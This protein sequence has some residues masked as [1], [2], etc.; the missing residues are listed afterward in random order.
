MDFAKIQAR[1]KEIRDTLKEFT[2]VSREVY[3]SHSYA[4]GYLES[5]L[6]QSMLGMS[7]SQREMILRDLNR[8]IESLQKKVDTVAA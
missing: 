2:D 1:H 5:L 3:G 8:S 7:K 6:V 4:A